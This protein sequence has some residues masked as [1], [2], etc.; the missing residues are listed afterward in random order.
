MMMKSLL[1]KVSE[2]FAGFIYLPAYP[3]DGSILLGGFCFWDVLI[4]DIHLR[5]RSPGEQVIWL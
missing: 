3:E 5:E 1:R 4:L 2:L